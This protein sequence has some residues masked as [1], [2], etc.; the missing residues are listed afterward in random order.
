MDGETDERHLI[1]RASVRALISPSEL[2]WTM[3]HAAADEVDHPLFDLQPGIFDLPALPLKVVQLAASA[4]HWD[5][6]AHYVR[7][8]QG[9]LEIPQM[10]QK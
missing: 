3:A 2:Q 5:V 9:V 10:R 4:L 7:F 6:T 1:A 8:A